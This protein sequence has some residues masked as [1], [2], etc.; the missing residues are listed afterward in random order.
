[1]KGLALISLYLGSQP[2]VIYWGLFLSYL[3]KIAKK[4]NLLAKKTRHIIAVNAK[5]SYLH[6][7]LI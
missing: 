2:S 4:I 3:F 5:Y 1:M 7:L 6:S